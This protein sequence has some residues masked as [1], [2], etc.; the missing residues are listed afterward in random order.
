MF[1]KLNS[2]KMKAYK[3]PRRNKSFF[4]NSIS[5]SLNVFLTTIGEVYNF[6]GPNEGP[7]MQSKH[8]ETSHTST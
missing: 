1:N 6:V 4:F 7:I 3:P 2:S 8:S 5:I